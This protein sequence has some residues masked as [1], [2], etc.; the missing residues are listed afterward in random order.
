M[1]VVIKDLSDVA[2]NV[3]KALRSEALIRAFEPAMQKR[4]S[5]DIRLRCTSD[6]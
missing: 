6:F 1:Y 2:M 5:L 4:L 3:R